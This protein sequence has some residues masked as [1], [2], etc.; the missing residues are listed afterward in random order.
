MQQKKDVK[1]SLADSFKTLALK[2]P[3]EKITIREITDGA[4]VI[5]VTFYNHFQDKYELLEWIFREEIMA[6]ARPLVQSSKGKDAIVCIFGALLADRIFYEHAARMEGQNSFE[7]IVTQCFAE[8][9]ETYLKHEAVSGPENGKRFSAETTADILAHMFSYGLLR[10]IRGGMAEDPEQ[11]AAA[12][13]HMVS[14]PL[15]DLLQLGE[16]NLHN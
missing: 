6:P 12:V 3:I 7:S 5:R 9:M 14:H 15:K 16:A 10:W 1:S 2:K 11:I 13:E 4:G 8:M